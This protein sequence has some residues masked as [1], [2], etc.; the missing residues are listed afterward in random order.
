MASRVE[1]VPAGPRNIELAVPGSK[2]LTNRALICAALAEGESRLLNASLSDDSRL[3]LAALKRLGVECSVDEPRC[4]VRIRGGRLPRGE[5]RF[6]LG[7]AGT[8]LRFLTSMLCLGQGAFVVDGSGR[9]RERPIGSLVDALRAL[10]ADIRYLASEGFPPIE[11]RAR[12]LSGGRARVAGDQSSQFLSSLLLAAPYARGPV[13][14]EVDG[15]VASR[16]YV[17]MTRQVME[18]F[19]GG[20]Y[21]ACEFSVEGDAAAAGYWWSMAAV[22]RGRARILGIGAA[23]AQ[24]EMGWVGDLRRMGCRVEASSDWTEVSASGALCGIDAA[25]NDHP[26]SVPTLAV[27][28]LFA[29]GPTRVRD[30]RHLRFKETDRLA[31]LARELTKLGARLVEHSDGLEIDPPVRTTPAE[32]ET[33]GDHRMA[34]SFAVAGAAASG[35]VIVDPECVAKSYPSFWRDAEKAGVRALPRVS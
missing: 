18:A 17:D 21:R 9:M 33:Y 31:A 8:S 11:I 19:G 15:A 30:V 23:C 32:I 25:M 29:A 1:I 12:G 4:E 3:L 10:G 24:P 35:I 26:D 34:M 14:V 27:A 16:P 28:A 13:E 5:A 20:P 2:S 22:T 6:E 7:N